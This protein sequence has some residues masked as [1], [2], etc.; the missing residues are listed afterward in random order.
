MRLIAVAGLLLLAACQPLPHPFAHDLP[1]PNAAIL[2]PPDSAG[3][4]VEPVAGAPQPAAQQLAAAMAKAL[5]DQDVPADTHARNKGSYRL[6]GTATTREVGNGNLLVTIA[7]QMREASGMPLSRQDSTL[8]VPAAAW[9]QGDTALAALARQSAPF[10]AKAVESTAPAPIADAS[11]VIAVQS[12]TG[13]PGDGAQSLARAMED[14]L[15]RSHLTL[16]E[17]PADKANFVV[18]A[19]VEVSPPADGKQEVKIAWLLRRADGGQVGE[20]QQDNAVPAGSLNGRW[21]VTAYEAANAAAPG[22]AALIAEIKRAA[23]PS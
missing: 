13:A 20:V 7:W 12:V 21:G 1:P 18:V 17:T 15:R 6:T 8:T 9:R 19:T 23:T 16:A 2:T 14:A 3:V 5:Q 11:P 4:I 10:F 22:I